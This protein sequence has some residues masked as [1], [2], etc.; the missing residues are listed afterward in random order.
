MSLSNNRRVEKLQTATV[1]HHQH[2]FNSTGLA[3]ADYLSQN[4]PD[5]T[6]AG[7]VLS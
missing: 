4:K 7:R 1:D 3:Q 5:E 6:R 2:S